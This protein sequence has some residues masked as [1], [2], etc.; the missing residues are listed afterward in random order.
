MTRSPGQSRTLPW[1]ADELAALDSAFSIVLSAHTDDRLPSGSV[2]IGVVVTGDGVF[3]RAYRGPVSGW[4]QA[5][6]TLGQG[7]IQIDG[8]VVAVRFDRTTPAD[9]PDIH[10]AID[11]AYTAK[12]G[13][14]SGGI[15][16]AQARDA[17][18]R[19]TPE[20]T[21]DPQRTSR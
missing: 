21:S 3:V 17:T 14:L 8:R 12:Y 13:S 20:S 18:V 2:E 16:T 9:A 19:I 6:Q 1:T 5:T 11:R 10:D 4:F 15:A 7:T